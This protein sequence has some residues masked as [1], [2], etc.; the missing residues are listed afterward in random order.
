MSAAV[1]YIFCHYHVRGGE[2]CGMNG[3]F[4]FL[5]QVATLHTIEL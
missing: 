3:E 5:L 2:A 1:R 4:A